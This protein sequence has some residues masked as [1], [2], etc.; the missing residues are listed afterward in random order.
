MKLRTTKRNAA[1]VAAVLLVAA[2]IGT[3]N[4]ASSSTE[5]SNAASCGTPEFR[6]FDFWVGDWDAFD[7]GGPAKSVARARIDRIL[8][9]CV[10]REDYQDTNGLKGQSFSIYDSSQ[11][12]WHQSWVTNRGQLLLLDG[13]FQH[14]EMALFGT[15]RTPEG[16]TR[17]VRGVWR[18]MDGGVRET[19]TTSL[20]GSKTW[21]PW[22]DIVFRPHKRALK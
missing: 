12:K 7:A 16:K 22:F 19:A 18:P 21:Q 3:V 17:H 10:L 4:P 13:S 5:M 15:D 1:T 11:K 8:G 14:G 6:Q 20:D 2:W 9:G